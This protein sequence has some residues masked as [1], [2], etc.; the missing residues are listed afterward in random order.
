[1]HLEAY[2]HPLD[3]RRMFE[4]YDLAARPREA[5]ADARAWLL[6]CEWAEGDDAHDTIRLLNAV[7]LIAA[8]ERHYEGGYR[9]FLADSLNL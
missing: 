8:V 3:E 1:M 2:K 5:A 7:G 6:D 9:Q 4:L